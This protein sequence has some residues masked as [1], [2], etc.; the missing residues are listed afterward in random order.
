MINQGHRF[1]PLM[2]DRGGR[3]PCSRLNLVVRQTEEG[4]SFLRLIGKPAVRKRL[5]N[6][7]NNGCEGDGTKIRVVVLS[8]GGFGYWGNVS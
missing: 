7:A 5:Q 1:V 2:E 4:R 8:G 3:E 6:F